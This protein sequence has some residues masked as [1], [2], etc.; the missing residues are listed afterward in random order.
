MIEIAGVQVSDR[1]AARLSLILNSA[2]ERALSDRV[3]Q[4]WDKVA[5]HVELAPGDHA[6]MLSALNQ[7]PRPEP[8]LEDLR[9]TLKAR[10]ARGA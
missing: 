8:E 9:L 7:T 4:A 2:G 5:D 10:V 3:E 6:R 1:A